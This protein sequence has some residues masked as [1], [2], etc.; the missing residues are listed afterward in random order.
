[1]ST[2]ILNKLVNICST[3]SGDEVSTGTS[4]SEYLTKE[5]VI[6]LAA[7]PGYVLTVVG[8]ILSSPTN[9][10]GGAWTML[11]TFEITPTVGDAVTVTR[12]YRKE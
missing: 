1:M 8:S 2:K 3:L 7:P 11:D 5:E 10:Y 9:E 6:D 12:W 4:S